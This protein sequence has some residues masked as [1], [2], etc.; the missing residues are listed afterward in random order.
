MTQTGRHAQPGL[1]SQL[2]QN[3]IFHGL[4][5]DSERGMTARTG[6]AVGRDLDCHLVLGSEDLSMQ[7]STIEFRH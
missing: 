6:A 2:H 4:K 1:L 5:V 7:T 3:P